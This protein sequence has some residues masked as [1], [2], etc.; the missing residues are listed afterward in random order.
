MIKLAGW[1]EAAAEF[2]LQQSESPAPTRLKDL[3]GSWSDVHV[4]DEDIQEIRRESLRNFPSED[5]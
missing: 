2:S 1:L 4:S 3:Y 5:V